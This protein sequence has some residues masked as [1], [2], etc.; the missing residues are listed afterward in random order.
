[1]YLAELE[2]QGFKSFANKTK[3]IFDSGITA[4]VGPNG[5]GKSN[6]VDS[7]RWVLGE[8]KPS[9]LRSASMSNVIFNGTATKKALNYADVSVTIHNNKGILPVE[10]TD[11]TI[12]RRLFRNG[13]SEYRLND[14]PCRLKDIV[15]LFMDTGM[16]TGAYSVIELKMVE[17]ILNDKTNNRRYL[18]E[19]AAGVMKYKERRKQTF[20]K[21]EETRLALQRL[22]DVLVVIRKSVRSLHNQAQKALKAEEHTEELRTLE[23]NLAKFELQRI[24][25]ELKPLHEKRTAAE[26]EK[27][28]LDRQIQQTEVG[29]QSSKDLLVQKELKLRVIQDVFN[30]TQSKIREADTTLRITKEKIINEEQ[31]IRQYEQDIFQAEKDIAELKENIIISK[32]EAQFL[33]EE[34]KQLAEESNTAQESYETFQRSETG[35][36]A[37]LRDIVFKYQQLNQ[38]LGLKETHKIKLESRL[39]HL[40]E[41]LDRIDRQF[42]TV[43]QEMDQILKEES[44][45]NYAKSQARILFEDAELRFERAQHR[46]ETLQGEINQ[47]KDAIRK[48][49]SVLDGLESEIQLLQSIAKSNETFPSSVRFLTEQKPQLFKTVSDVFATDEH[50]ALALESILGESLYFVITENR[51]DAEI[52]IR[53]LKENKKGRVTFIPISELKKNANVHPKSIAEKIQCETRYVPLRD[54]LLGNIILMDSLSEIPAEI[55]NHSCSGVSLE[56]DI[57]RAEGW[58]TSGSKEKNMGI[59]L[60]LKD[61]IMN[62]ERQA[63][64]LEEESKQRRRKLNAA[65]TEFQSIHLITIQDDVREKSQVFRKKENELSSYLAQKSVLKTNMNGYAIRRQHI[66]EQFSAIEKEIAEMQPSLNDLKKELEKYAK[67]ETDVR[68]DLEKVSENRNR[69]QERYN[70]IKL[71]FQEIKNHQ[72]NFLRDAERDEKQISGIKERLNQRAEQATSSKDRIIGYRQ[73]VEDDGFKLEEQR[74]KLFEIKARLDEADLDCSKERRKINQFDTTLR[75]IHRKKEI[76]INLIHELSMAKSQYDMLSKQIADHLWETYNLLA[77]QLENDLPEEFDAT[78]LKQ[79][80]NSLKQKLKNIG[81]INPLAIEEYEEEQKK[82]D[83]YEEQIADLAGAESKLKQTIDEINTTAQERFLTT[84]NLIRTNFIDVF[85]TL[86]E[87]TDNCDLILEENQEDP[88]ESRIDIFAQPKGKRPSHINQLSGGEKT[89]TAIALLFA[90]YLVKPSPFC[91]LDEVDAPLDDANIERFGKIIRR[92][93]LNTQFIIITHNKKT[94]EKAERMYGVTMQETGVSSLVGVDMK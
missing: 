76:N 27:D 43:N 32:K 31:T 82:L 68:A 33:S 47:L 80:V 12:N 86:F 17:E 57:L 63:I 4:I 69:A 44:K 90:I 19:E 87:E 5:C 72:D 37:L 79:E 11:V 88:L 92:F 21:L 18:F 2:L 14:S 93:S 26:L 70:E 13:D 56:G 9:A 1:M 65:E 45:V 35:K 3:V 6:I 66:R 91:I 61:K 15:D 20:K 16:G 62:L 71:K 42:E 51:E 55:Q 83:F 50:H 58:L 78:T 84:F 77:D 7:L 67:Q 59:R 24:E 29:L 40:D 25:A 8:Q 38:M 64:S 41:E 54:L 81:E 52:G 94:M 46:R 23:L 28:A 39:E 34:V 36:Q 73:I 53:L 74:E 22:E 30:E 60:G 48:D 10:F 75:D 89:L 49:D 85:K